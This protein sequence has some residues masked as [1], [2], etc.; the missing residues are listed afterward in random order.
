MMISARHP[1]SFAV[2]VANVH[3]TCLAGQRSPAS[4][5]FYGTSHNVFPIVNVTIPPRDQ[6]VVVI[7]YARHGHGN[8]RRA[9]AGDFAI[10]EQKAAATR[11][12]GR[13]GG[14]EGAR[15]TAFCAPSLSSLRP[16]LPP[17]P[18][19][20]HC[21]SSS[22]F[23]GGQ[24]NGGTAFA[25]DGRTAMCMSIRVRRVGSSLSLPRKMR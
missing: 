13:E 9:C 19:L 12:G 24:W 21:V 5:I 11:V 25:R 6:W 14:N 20:I 22:D 18:P 17:L 1:I 8:L 4:D 2:Q 23:W 16:S 3:V 7:S 15:L 10:S